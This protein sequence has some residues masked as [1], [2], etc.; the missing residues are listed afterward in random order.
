MASRSSG[1]DRTWSHAEVIFGD[2]IGDPIGD[3][4]VKLSDMV[5]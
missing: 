4:G 5:A 3:L 2:E 1:V